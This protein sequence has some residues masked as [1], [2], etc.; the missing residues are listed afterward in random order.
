MLAPCKKKGAP[1]APYPQPTIS[2][3]LGGGGVAYKDRARP[4]PSAKGNKI[5]SGC[6]IALIFIFFLAVDCALK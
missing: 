6:L 1:L 2:Q 4:P 3:N 5:R